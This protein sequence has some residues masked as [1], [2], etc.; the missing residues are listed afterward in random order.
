MYSVS[1]QK[2]FTIVSGRESAGNR[3]SYSMADRS[4]IGIF[5][6]GDIHNCFVVLLCFDL[7]SVRVRSPS[8]QFQRL[9]EC[10]WISTHLGRVH[11]IPG[12]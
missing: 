10:N 2:A 12:V 3:I 5:D 11:L 8:P 9:F 1:D 7:H 4:L 6:S